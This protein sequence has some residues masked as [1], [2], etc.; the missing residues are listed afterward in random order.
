MRKSY[1]NKP[2]SAREKLRNRLISKVR[3]IVE[4]AF[5]TL[6][7]RLDASRSAYIGLKKVA[8]QLRLKAICFNLLKAVNKVEMA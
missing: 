3:F 8:A 1:R 2:L 5:G 7:R 4:Q 6:K